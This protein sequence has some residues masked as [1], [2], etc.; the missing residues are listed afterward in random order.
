MLASVWRFTHTV[1]GA[2]D[3]LVERRLVCRDVAHTHVCAFVTGASWSE[4]TRNARAHWT[5]R[6][7]LC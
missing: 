1:H 7:T 2:I 6:R 3:A 4:F 5:T